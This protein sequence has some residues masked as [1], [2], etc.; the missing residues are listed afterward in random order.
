[1]KKLE[2]VLLFICTYVSA[3]SKSF[4]T[5]PD[6]INDTPL[7]SMLSNGTIH[8][9]GIFRSLISLAIVIGLIYLTAW[10]Y[11]KLNG[12]NSQKFTKDIEN[13]GLNKFKVI[14]S[15]SLGAQK[16]LH[17]VEINGKYLVLGSTP[18]SIN[19]LKEF[20]KNLTDLKNSL[21]IADVV[22]EKNSSKNNSQDNWMNDLVNKYDDLEEDNEKRNKDW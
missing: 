21:D 13:L 12:F 18:N 8:E 16:N 5:E 7:E 19:L 10:L 14:A 2:L 4:A 3:Y 6:Y 15:Q 9:G 17:V 1:M 22:F 20:D 11:K